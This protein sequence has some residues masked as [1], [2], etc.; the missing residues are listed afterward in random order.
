MGSVSSSPLILSVMLADGVPSQ[1]QSSASCSVCA[2][3][4]FERK[5]RDQD[6]QATHHHGLRPASYNPLK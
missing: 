6:R 3:H 2:G 1:P 4:D 5:R